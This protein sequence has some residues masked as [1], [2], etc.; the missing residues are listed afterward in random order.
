MIIIRPLVLAS[1]LVTSGGSSGGGVPA[2]VAPIFFDDETEQAFE[3]LEDELTR[4]RSKF[5]IFS[6][7]GYL[8]A[9]NCAQLGQLLAA[10]A[11]LEA[12]ARP[13]VGEVRMC[14]SLLALRSAGAPRIT[15]FDHEKL[16]SQVFNALRL[17]TLR[18]SFGPRLD[19]EHETLADFEFVTTDV[20]AHAVELSEDDWNYSVQVL[21]AADF[22]HDGIEDLLALFYDDA[23]FASYFSLST[24]ILSRPQANGPIFARDVQSL[25]VVAARLDSPTSALALS[26]ECNE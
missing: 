3:S 11:T 21:A 17:D 12:G 13:T 19:D 16:G 2:A 9:S 4:T 5:V 25:L 22:D 15:H 18:S 10:G 8:E 20:Q 6:G 14:L 1:V 23:R 24:L 26:S 7:E